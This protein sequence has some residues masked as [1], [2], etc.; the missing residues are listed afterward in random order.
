M[1]TLLVEDGTGALDVHSLPT[2]SGLPLRRS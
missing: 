1:A 2:P